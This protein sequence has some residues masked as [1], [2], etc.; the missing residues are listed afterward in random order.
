M[1]AHSMVWYGMVWYGMV[2]YG[3]VWY[4]MVWYGMVW[5]GMVWYGMVYGGMVW[6][7]AVWYGV[8]W[9]LLLYHV[10]RPLLL[11]YFIP[12]T[13]HRYAFYHD[14]P[15]AVTPLIMMMPHAWHLPYIYTGKPYTVIIIY[16]VLAC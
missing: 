5:Y 16:M 11:M 15:A 10:T 12:P 9:C 13:T 3:M 1:T 8:V 14:E 4:G 6:Y 7:M 2:W